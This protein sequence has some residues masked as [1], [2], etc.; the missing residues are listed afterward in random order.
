MLIFPTWYSPSNVVYAAKHIELGS[1]GSSWLSRPDIRPPS[2]E[3]A[4]YGEALNIR[5]YKSSVIDV[6]GISWPASFP[7]W[8]GGWRSSG[9]M[10]TARSLAVVFERNKVEGGARGWANTTFDGEVPYIANGTS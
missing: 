10:K 1:D 4:N 8:Q 9:E 7:L 5:T 3:G 2:C 6:K